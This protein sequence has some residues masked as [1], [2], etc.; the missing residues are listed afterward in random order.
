MSCWFQ[1][2]S[3]SVAS[4]I[5]VV[6]LCVGPGGCAANDVESEESAGAALTEPHQAATRAFC[7]TAM[8]PI[9]RE[10]PSR[11]N[12]SSTDYDVIY[13]VSGQ[14]S[15]VN[16]KSV[17]YDWTGR[18]S[19]INGSRIDYDWTGRPSRLNGEA[20]DYDWASNVTKI[21]GHQVQRDAQGRIS[22]IRDGR[23]EYS[24]S[25]KV[26]SIADRPV[27]YRELRIVTHTNRL[28]LCLAAFAPPP[29]RS[30]D[31]GTEAGHTP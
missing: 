20:V 2:V 27:S 8:F 4:R 29:A 25:G 11:M 18:P 1:S 10:A 30:L 5:T 22:Q 12:G 28:A 19:N 16:G 26:L 13:D 9:G 7:G 6:V 23:V 3:A 31:G 17:D 15:K 14:V 21:G 24:A